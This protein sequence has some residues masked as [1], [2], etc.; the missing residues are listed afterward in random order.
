MLKRV[1]FDLDNTLMPWKEEYKEAAIKTI[2]ECNLNIDYESFDKLCD[3]YEEEYKAYKTS[4]MANL[5]S[6][7]TNT[8]IDEKVIKVWLK[9]LGDM[10]EKDEKLIDLL[11]YLSQKYEL[12]I[13]T[14]W[15]ISS[16]IKRLEKAQIKDY[17]I[18]IIGGDEFIKPS[19]ESFQK[20]MGNHKAIECLMVGDSY[21]TDIKGAKDIG[22]KTIEITDKKSK[23]T[24][25]EIYE[26]KEL[27]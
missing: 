25:K 27:L 6:K 5:L 8:K 7:I 24:I 13:L 4:N 15:F 11:E 12:V 19:K 1:I 22:I 18:D 14:N 9:Y 16:Q 2:K 20:A 21:K 10:S 3:L 17:F 26:L 23:D